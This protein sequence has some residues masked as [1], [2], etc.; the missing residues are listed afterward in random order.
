MDE[1][2]LLVA[3]QRTQL[4][5]GVPLQKEGRVD[6]EG[7]QF[8][9]ALSRQL[10]YRSWL[11]SIHM[12]RNT[13]HEEWG[14][15]TQEAHTKDHGGQRAMQLGCCEVLR[16]EMASEELLQGGW[17]ARPCCSPQPP[18]LLYSQPADS[19]WI[20]DA[21]RPILA[22]NLPKEQEKLWHGC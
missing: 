14:T 13:G 10:Q 21:M 4:K 5:F 2:N 6:T 18:L 17:G 19:P 20:W 15:L 8:H 22:T 1:C 3:W 16:K 9:G 11:V 12:T 7:H